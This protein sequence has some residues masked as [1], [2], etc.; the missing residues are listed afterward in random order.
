[1]L[2]TKATTA[3]RD[4]L[5]CKDMNEYDKLQIVAFKVVF[6]TSLRSGMGTDYAFVVA[7]DTTDDEH[8]ATAIR[9]RPD[10]IRQWLADHSDKMYNTS[11][12]WFGSNEGKLT[13]CE[14]AVL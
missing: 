6:W 7:L 12:Y 11:R 14:G 1:M 3:G 2:R 5:S 10:M 9:R 13:A 4:G 8:M